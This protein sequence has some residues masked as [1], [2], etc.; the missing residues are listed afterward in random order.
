MSWPSSKLSRRETR[1]CKRPFDAF[2]AKSVELIR[3]G[4]HLLVIDLFPPTSR[5]PK[6]IHAAIW[7]SDFEPVDYSA[8]E[9]SPLTLASY[10]ADR[11]PE[12]FVDRPPSASRSL[13]CRFFTIR[14]TT[15]PCHSKK[16]I[17]L[18]GNAVPE[19]WRNEIEPLSL[20]NGNEG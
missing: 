20:H 12:A 17:W 7:R 11:W 15:S 3:R 1:M 16:P 19:Y 5:D 18:P 14:T 10:R 13:I 8:P 2:V 4:I 6:G 9:D